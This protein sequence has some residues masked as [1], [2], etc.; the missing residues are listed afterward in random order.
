M[1]NKL[2]AEFMGYP[3]KM[4]VDPDVVM[5]SDYHCVSIQSVPD[6]D[7]LTV[8][9]NHGYS[10]AEAYGHELVDVVPP[11]DL[12]WDWLMPVIEKIRDVVSEPEELDVLRDLIWDY[13][14]HIVH[15]EVIRLITD[16]N[17]GIIK[18]E[19]YEK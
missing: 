2:I 4:W 19:D 1:D 3:C 5:N 8:C 10:E 13:R 12:F 14:I 7:M 15:Q 9:Y 16:I 18:T 6:S 11:F 17:N